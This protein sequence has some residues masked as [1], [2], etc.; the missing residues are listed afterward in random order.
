MRGTGEACR[1]SHPGEALRPSPSAALAVASTLSPAWVSSG[2]RHAV[3]DS[4]GCGGVDLPHKDRYLSISFW[5]WG[6]AET[7]EALSIIC[8]AGD[9]RLRW[10]GRGTWW[11]YICKAL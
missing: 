3:T 11:S 6:T 2:G 4:M 7:Q 1:G 9:I 10:T 5:G 8:R